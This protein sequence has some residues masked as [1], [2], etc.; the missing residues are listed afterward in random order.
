M[1][2]LRFHCTCGESGGANL[3]GRIAPAELDA[4]CDRIRAAWA[5]AHTGPGHAPC[6]PREAANARR[7]AERAAAGEAVT[8]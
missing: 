5:V 1:T 7:R 6:G 3:A 4:L 8:P 2:R